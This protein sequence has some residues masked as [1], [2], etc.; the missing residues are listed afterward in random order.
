MSAIDPKSVQTSDNLKKEFGDTA[1]F[2][3]EWRN[4]MKTLQS[5]FP[6]PWKEEKKDK[7]FENTFL[8]AVALIDKMKHARVFQDQKAWQGYLGDPVLPDYSKCKDVKLNE[9]MESLEDVIEELVSYFDG[10]PNWNHPQTMWNVAPPPNTAAVIGTTLCSIFNPN[11]LE[12]DA[13]WNVAK[14]EIESAAMTAQ[15]IGWDPHEAG[16]V[17]TFGGTGC[18]LY[19]LKLALTTVLGKDSRYTGIRE[20][21]QVL[22]SSQGHYIKSNCPD[23]AGLGMNNVR[24]I[25]VDENNCMSIDHLSQVMEECKREGQPVVMIVCTAGTTDAWAVD[26]IEDVRELIDQFEN[27]RGHPKPLLYSDAV[28]GWPWLAFST[29]DFT[30]NPFQFS[31]KALKVLE[32]NYQ[33]VR[34]LYLSDAIGVDFHKTGWT[35][36]ISS[37]FM[38]KDYAKFTKFLDRPSPAYLQEVTPYNPLQFTLETSRNGAS[39]MAAWATLRLFGREGFQ[40]MLGRII[41]VGLFLREL[42]ARD[43]NIVCVNPDNYGFVTLFRVYPSHINAEEQYEKELNDPQYREDL[44]VYNLL[45]Q[46]VANKLF[47]MLRDPNQKVSGWENPPILGFTSGYRPPAYVPDEIDHRYCIYALKAFPMS[48]NSNELSMLNVRNYVIKTCE[49]VVSEI[50]KDERL[51]SEALKIS[52]DSK[53]EPEIRSTDNWWGDN[54]FIPRKYLIPSAALSVG[55]ML[56]KVPICAHLIEYQLDELVN[57]S[58]TTTLEAGQILFAEGDKANNVYLILSGK[59]KVYKEDVD[60]NKIEFATLGKGSFF[61]EMALFDNG[62]RSASVRSLEDSNFCVIEGDKF[63]D[64][65]LE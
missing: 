28:I 11:L 55:E 19:G 38:V 26:P 47:E 41:E 51:D 17:F 35:P 53:S 29:Y 60:G 10:M 58:K 39:S 56:K 45:Q 40:V 36:Y 63:L 14:T 22:V 13:S 12:G 20:E 43:N 48:P 16:G 30:Q 46:R 65:V 31:Q 4:R 8:N 15:L 37:L 49:L 2:S 25:Q 24:E 9:N 5:A 27:A 52:P 32:K 61:G 42:F 62:I 3:A 33:Q 18:Y 44:R 1:R 57:C 50:L 21:G 6:S 64:L 7:I 23:W 54:E 34:S 59:V